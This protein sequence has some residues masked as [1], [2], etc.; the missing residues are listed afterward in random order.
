MM[1]YPLRSKYHSATHADIIKNA[2][3]GLMPAPHFCC[4]SESL[5]KIRVF[6]VAP[7][8]LRGIDK[9]QVIIGKTLKW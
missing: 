3:Q 6:I 8:S 5:Q 7:Y 4:L 9:I 1:S 2:V